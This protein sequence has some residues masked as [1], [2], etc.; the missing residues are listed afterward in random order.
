MGKSILVVD[1]SSSV[2]NFINVSLSMQGFNVVVATDGMDALE[3]LPGR[4]FDL[5]ITDLNMPNLDGFELIAALREMPEYKTVPI[6]ILTTLTDS[7]SRERGAS[8][9]I[10]SYLIKPFSTEKIQYEVA[11]YISW[12]D[13]TAI[14]E[15]HE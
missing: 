15:E 1:D 10:D 2:R 14:E 13:E 3:K 7:E 8:L 5:V 6:I 9:G 4:L 11:K 12:Y